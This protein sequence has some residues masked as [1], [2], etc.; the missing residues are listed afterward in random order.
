MVAD[1]LIHHQADPFGAGR[2]DDDLLIGI[3]FRSA[4][5]QLA[6]AQERLGALTER[7]AKASR[8]RALRTEVRAE[9]K[10]VKRE[11]ALYGHLRRAFGKNG[12]PS[13]I[14]EETL[15]EI[16]ARANALLERLSR[17]RTR[18]ALETLKDKKTGGGTRET[19]D[20]RITDDQGVGRNDD[21]MLHGDLCEVASGRSRWTVVDMRFQLR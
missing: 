12:I 10:E 4:G 11:R 5:K 18:V 19:L 3:G 17:G 21:I 16:E 2:D 13:L 20:I 14:I 1:D 6:Q 9:L 7:L 8:D 15:P